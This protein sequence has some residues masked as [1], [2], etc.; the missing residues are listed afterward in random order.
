[1]STAATLP[2]RGLELQSISQVWNDHQSGNPGHFQK[3]NCQ[4]LQIGHKIVDYNTYLLL[5]NMYHHHLFLPACLQQLKMSCRNDGGLII[6]KVK[7]QFL[8]PIC[9]E[10]EDEGSRSDGA[11]PKP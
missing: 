8:S 5:S 3:Q 9:D 6:I 4:F 10:T 2:V 7:L 1:M 11:Y